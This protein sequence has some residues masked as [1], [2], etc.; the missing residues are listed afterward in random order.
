MMDISILML[1]HNA[2][3][4]VYKSITT[5]KNITKTNI[6]YEILVVDNKSSLFTRCLLKYLKKKKYIDKLVFNTDNSLF[7]KGNN[8]ASSL[9][10]KSTKYYLLLNS[11]IE[12]RNYDWLDKLLAIHPVEGG[13][14][15]YGFV[16]SEP[17]RADGY[18]M[19]IDKN[20]YDKYKLDEDF[21]WFWSITKIESLVLKEG[22]RIVSVMNHEKYIHHYG[23]KSGKGF[24]NAAGMDIDIEEVKKWFTKGNVEMI[25]NI[26]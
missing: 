10:D 8:I 16:K 15:S 25:D 7:A 21:A 24:E 12:V 13:I 2:P 18:C 9:S 22:K 20:L 3:K 4:Y 17:K 5:I 1:T 6:K 14:S 19:M 11:D 23:G 26:D